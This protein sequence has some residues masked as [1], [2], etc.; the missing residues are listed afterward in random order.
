MLL[1]CLAG[2]CASTR[3]QCWWLPSSTTQILQLHPGQVAVGRRWEM[4]TDRLKIAPAKTEKWKGNFTL[5][6][7]HKKK[8][9]K[10]KKKYSR[11]PVSSTSKVHSQQIQGCLLCKAGWELKLKR[12]LVLPPTAAVVEGFWRTVCSEQS[13]V[14]QNNP[15]SLIL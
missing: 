9:K 11:V 13:P 5:K 7:R 10:K 8:E 12:S 14:S 15:S 4:E 2:C 3:G 6:R 1:C